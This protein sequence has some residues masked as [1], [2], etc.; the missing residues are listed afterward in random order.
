MM[1]GCLPPNPPKPLRTLNGFFDFAKL[2]RQ[3]SV[4]CEI[5]TLNDGQLF[6]VGRF[7]F[8][9]EDAARFLV[10]LVDQTACV[11]G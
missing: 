3:S 2:V 8:A 11:R 9:G 1:G 5:A 10:A 6:G 7:S 4:T